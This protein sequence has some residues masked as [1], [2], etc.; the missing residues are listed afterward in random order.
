[1]ITDNCSRNFFLSEKL[2]IV[3][4]YK[5]NAECAHCII[6]S[7]TQR[8]EKLDV[9]VAKEV[10]SKCRAAGKKYVNFT[11]GE[12]FL[13]FDE[14]IEI[15]G[16]A[17]SLGY[18]TAVDTNGFWAKDLKSTYDTL[19]KL[20]SVGLNEISPSGDAFHA[21]YVPTKYIK[22]IIDVCKDVNLVCEINF[23]SS[24]NYD[25]D[26][27]IFEI[28][29]LEKEIYYTEGLIPRGRCNVSIAQNTCEKK[30]INELT[31]NS[32]NF[33]SV[34]PIGQVI[35]NVDLS[36]YNKEFI[37]TPLYIG[38]FFEESLS[39]ILSKE[40][41]S[42]FVQAI[43]NK[44][45]NYLHQLLAQD[46]IAGSQYLNEY[47]HRMYFT[48]TEYYIDLLN[49]DFYKNCLQELIAVLEHS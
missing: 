9:Q 4:T 5:C 23:Y 25:I 34:N 20:K 41:N 13:Y 36:A 47:N 42:E 37:N 26:K 7:N 46:S 6:E 17:S 43:Y 3:Y 38:N 30:Y 8:N 19:N 44:P 33:L 35:A 12:L 1:M 2:N 22:N 27:N 45:Y 10:L 48:L 29:N 14:L 21:V 31:D 18:Y 15:V 24:G 11:G 40:K 28:L 39:S 49:N 16:F 32:S